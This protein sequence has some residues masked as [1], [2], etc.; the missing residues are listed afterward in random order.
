MGSR[1][2]TA[3]LPPA[4]LVEELDALVEPRRDADPAI[5]WARTQSWHITTSFMAEVG[6]DQLDG[7]VD[8]LA[9]VAQKVQSFEVSVGG[10]VVFPDAARAKVLALGVITGAE[11]LGRLSSAARHAASRAGTRADGA[12]FVPHL[13][14]A[15][16]RAGVQATR[17]M[18]IVDSFPGWGWRADELCLIESRHNGR[19]YEVLRRY[20]LGCPASGALTQASG[21]GS[22][23]SSGR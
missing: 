8:L 22:G 17:W 4:H 5:R 12:S 21:D 1:L 16:S 20:R 14:L 6:G 9:G 2:F 3:V 7:L 18:G 11:D 15:R 13:T 23:I 19:H 10:A